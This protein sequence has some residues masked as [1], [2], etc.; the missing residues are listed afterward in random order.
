[1]AL[2]EL[3]EFKRYGERMNARN[4]GKISMLRGSLRWTAVRMKMVS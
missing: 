3:E 1:M 2:D 4:P